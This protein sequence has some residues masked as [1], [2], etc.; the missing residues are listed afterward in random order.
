MKRVFM[1]LFCI[2][3]L[4]GC[5]SQKTFQQFFNT[6]KNEIGVT[7]FQ[8]PNFM[9]TILSSISPEINGFFGNVKDFKFITFND[10]SDFKRQTLVNEINLVTDNGFSDILRVNSLE[11]TKIVSVVED[12]DIV[13]KA[14]IFNANVTKASAF[15][16]K[17]NFDPN[18][19]KVLSET[20]Q[21]EDLS[22]KLL[23]HYQ[24]PLSSPT[25]EPIKIN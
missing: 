5:S 13:R 20:N 16:L 4:N 6:H 1:I 12:G 9:R 10:L 24:T 14:I 8:V 19:L 7:A 25:I 18:K 23:Q 21:F 3:I 11:K 17:G 2:T 22:S 15:Y